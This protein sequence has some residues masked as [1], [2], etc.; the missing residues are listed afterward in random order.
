MPLCVHGMSGTILVLSLWYRY[1]QKANPLYK[2]PNTRQIAFSFT[3]GTPIQLSRYTV[4]RLPVSCG[5]AAN[6][7]PAHI[8]VYIPYS[9]IIIIKPGQLPKNDEIPCNQKKYIQQSWTIKLLGVFH[10]LACSTKYSQEH[11]ESKHM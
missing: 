3:Y 1:R 5:P 7:A 11:Q 8:I 2:A 9:I 10:L 6:P 4:L